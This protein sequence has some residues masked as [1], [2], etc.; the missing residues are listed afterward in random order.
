[1]RAANRTFWWVAQAWFEALSAG[2]LP[3]DVTLKRLLG[4]LNLQ[5]R[6]TI[7]ERAPVA[8]QLTREMLFGLAGV[9]A[10]TPRVAAVRAGFALERAIPEGYEEPRYGRLDARVVRAAREAIGKARSALDKVTRGNAAEL[11]AFSQAIDTFCDNVQQ[12][13][14]EGL[15]ALGRAFAECARGWAIGRGCWARHCR[16]SW[17]PRSCSRS[18]RWRMA[19][20]RARTMTA[21]ATRW[22]A[23][24]APPSRATVRRTPRCPSGCAA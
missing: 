4:R 5:L 16:W 21:T 7:E 12:M 10:G 3:V 20:V 1:V 14:T 6:K 22:R 9:Q 23:G 2:A 19:P 8:G 18:R 17:P 24:W 13:P 11:A 15:R